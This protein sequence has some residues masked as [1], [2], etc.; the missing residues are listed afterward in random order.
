M[1]FSLRARRQLTDRQ[2]AKLDF[3]VL[4][5]ALAAQRAIC[6]AG[7]A[8]EQA[9]VRQPGEEALVE[10]VLAGPRWR[11]AASMQQGCFSRAEVGRRA[12]DL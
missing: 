3:A 2:S 4:T 7:R 1:A 12:N 5:A 10:L 11:Q 6:D 8:L 9:P